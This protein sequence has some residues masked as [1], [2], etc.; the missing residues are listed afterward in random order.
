M[1]GERTAE[2]RIQK[3]LAR[4][5]VAS[6]RQVE[7]WVREGRLTVNGAAASLGTK[8]GPRDRIALDGRP[9]RMHPAKATAAP[10]LVMYHRT[11]GGSLKRSEDGSPSQWLSQLPGHA[12]RRWVPLSPLPVHD[13]GLELLTTDGDLSHAFT[14]QFSRVR[15]EY[16]LRVFG[17]PRLD[18]LEHLKS[19]LLEDGETLKIES[20][21]LE[22][23]E[24]INRWFKLTA[25][26]AGA[27][28][29]HRLCSAAGLQVNRL[30]R[31]TLG[32]ITMDRALSRGKVRALELEQ[33]QAL[34]AI[35]GL[36]APADAPEPVRAK[37]KMP[38]PMKPGKKKAAVKRGRAPVRTRR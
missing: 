12:S 18:Q 23:G 3:V 17:D 21:E 9:V 22:G 10:G 38:A 6:R 15:T 28:D 2:E 8:I 33:V 4:A 30:I 29:I 20:V 16:A 34:Y 1:T 13:S 27:R 37:K 11:S 19:G 26:G 7:Q 35:A 24:G 32:P 31:V 14:R 36:Q 5:G 25:Q